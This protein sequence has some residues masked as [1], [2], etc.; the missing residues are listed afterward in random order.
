MVFLAW[1]KTF[2][3][4]TEVV[5]ATVATQIAVVIKRHKQ[6]GH[7]QAVEDA[8]DTEA[9]VHIAI[10]SVGQI[11]HELED[12]E[13]GDATLPARRV[14]RVTRRQEVVE[15]Q[16]HV[17]H[18]VEGEDGRDAGPGRVEARV[19]AENQHAAVVEDVQKRDLTRLVTHHHEDGVE[20]LVDLGDAVECERAL[21]DDARAAREDRWRHGERKAVAGERA[22]AEET[23]RQIVDDQ[24]LKHKNNNNSQHDSRLWWTTQKCHGNS[25]VHVH[26][27]HAMY[28]WIS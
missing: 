25:K 5:K 21:Q 23:A 27:H 26:K 20:Q 24:Q 1:S 14:E 2:V 6:R 13:L 17:H 10:R 3:S 9:V 28:M 16:Q 12:L 7:C 22:G 15:V 19:V 18:G 4:A 8:V 11:E